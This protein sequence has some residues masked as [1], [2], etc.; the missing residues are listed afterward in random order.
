MIRDPVLL[1]EIQR[2]FGPDYV[3]S[4]SQLEQY[5]QNPFMFLLQRILKV[6]DQEE[7]EEDTSVLTSGT[8]G[9]ALLERFYVECHGRLPMDLNAASAELDRIAFRA[10]LHRIEDS[11]MFVLCRRRCEYCGRGAAQRGHHCNLCKRAHHDSIA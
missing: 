2:R 3:W 6:E 10:H 5:A 11:M 9:H 4:A 1:E 8:I 7:A